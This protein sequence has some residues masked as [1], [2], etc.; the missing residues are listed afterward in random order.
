MLIMSE[1]STCLAPDQ[2]RSL[3]EC[4][5]PPNDLAVV[6]DHLSHCASCRAKLEG[7]IGGPDWWREA[8]ES[9]TAPSDIDADFDGDM[10]ST[11]HKDVL[12]LLGPTDDPR[13]MG[14]VG[15]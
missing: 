6:E 15:T 2:M 10:N 5:L 13:M 11:S 7:A 3:L 4:E 12:R 9:L 1:S 14:R 8:R